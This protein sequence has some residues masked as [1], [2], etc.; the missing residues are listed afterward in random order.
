MNFLMGGGAMRRSIQENIWIL[1]SVFLEKNTVQ[2]YNISCLDEG[3]PGTLCST[4]LMSKMPM[5]LLT[6]KSFIQKSSEEDYLMSSSYRFTLFF[7][8]R[9]LSIDQRFN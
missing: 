8:P 4:V 7:I 3:E 9:R 1:S 2:K 6:A 5:I